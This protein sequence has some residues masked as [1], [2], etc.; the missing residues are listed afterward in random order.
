MSGLYQRKLR[1]LF[2]SPSS[3]SVARKENVHQNPKS[4][5]TLACLGHKWDV[6]L[7]YLGAAR[8]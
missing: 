4:V 1:D 5:F 7:I 6:T 2:L 8:L 3:Q